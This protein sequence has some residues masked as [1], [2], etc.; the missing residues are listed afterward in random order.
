MVPDREE[1]Q[2]WEWE[3]GKASQPVYLERARIFRRF[4]FSLRI[5]FLCHF[6]LMIKLREGLL[7]SLSDLPFSLLPEVRSKGLWF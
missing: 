5:R 7:V 6:A 1:L 4:R 2:S 3:R